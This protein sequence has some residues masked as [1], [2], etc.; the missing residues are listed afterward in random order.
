MQNNELEIVDDDK[1][2]IDRHRFVFI[3]F[4]SDFGTNE[5]QVFHF[6][7]AVNK[8]CMSVGYQTTNRHFEL[9]QI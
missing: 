6:L 3:F 4:F 9:F 8:K 2:F 5:S 7:H 1:E